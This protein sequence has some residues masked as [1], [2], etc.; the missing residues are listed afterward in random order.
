MNYQSLPDLNECSV[1]FNALNLGSSEFRSAY[2]TRYAYIVG[3]MYKGISSKEMVV[4]A[5]KAG[6]LAFFGTGG[7][8]L[9]GIEQSINF[10]QD[11]LDSNQPY[12]MNLLNNIERPDLEMQLVNLFLSK[13]VRNIE[14]AAYMEISAP[15]VKFRISGLRQTPSGEVVPGNRVIAKVS[16]PEVAEA[17]MRPPPIRI[18]QSLLDAGEISQYEA[19]L[20]QRIPVAH[21][22]CVESDSGGHT[23]QGV[24]YVVL[25]AIRNLS[26]RIMQEESYSTSFRIGAAGGIGTPDAAAAAFM[27]GADFIATGS[28]N[29]CTVEAATSE[30]VKNILQNIAIQDTTY[31]PAGDMFE[32]GAKMQVV[33]RGLFFSSRANKLYDI[34][35]RHNSLEELDSK[36]LNQIQEKY[37][38]RPIDD[39]WQETRSYYQK[40]MPDKLRQIENNPKMKMAAIFKWYFIHST[41]LAMKG[42]DQQKVDYQIHCGPALGAFNSWVKG[43]KYETWKS[44]KVAEIGELLMEET[45]RVLTERVSHLQVH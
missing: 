25:P 45:A 30:V 38:G 5:G 12:G 26:Q 18:V 20:S 24:A 19:E 11:N 40:S 2:S 32:I 29:Q 33:Q 27:L 9:K 1:V 22:I 39:V 31:A 4:A 7:I 21:D 3:A 6:I 37:F 43:S 36:T 8:S 10:I 44:R 34:Y 35:L 14:A 41:R 42:S 15:L 13:G 17:F 28:I 23:D 16:R